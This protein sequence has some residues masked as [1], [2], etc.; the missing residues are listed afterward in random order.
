MVTPQEQLQNR[1]MLQATAV[2][3]PNAFPQ[4][5]TTLTI[6]P[7]AVPAQDNMF[8]RPLIAPSQAKLYQGTAAEE[9]FKAQ[10]EV[11]K[12]SESVNFGSNL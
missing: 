11:N 3:I 2:V 4:G 9:A 8:R 10:L 5:T 12:L 1:T 7:K 6:Q